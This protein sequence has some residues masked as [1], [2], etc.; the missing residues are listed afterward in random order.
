M[1]REWYRRVFVT[2]ALLAVAEL[3]MWIPLPG[4][5]GL[6]LAMLFPNVD[7][8]QAAV[9]R[10]RM[11]PGALGI[12]PYVAASVLVVLVLRPRKSRPE[13]PED[14]ELPTRIAAMAIAFLQG[15]AIAIRWGSMAAASLDGG[16][17]LPMSPLSYL[18]IATSVA[19]GTALLIVLAHA[20][21]RYGIGNGVCLI[22]LAQ[23]LRQSALGFNLARPHGVASQEA[24]LPTMVATGVTLALFVRFLRERVD[25]PFVPSLGAE[26]DRS[27]TVV[28]LRSSGI[29]V[30]GVQLAIG[31]LAV[32]L[33]LPEEW[34]GLGAFDLLRSH[35]VAWATS[36]VTLSVPLTL[37]FTSWA[38]DPE[39]LG[40][41]ASRWG[42][43]LVQPGLDRRL[44]RGMLPGMLLL[45]VAMVAWMLFAARSDW[46]LPDFVT[47]LIVA[48]ISTSVYERGLL[49]SRLAR[50][51]EQV[52]ASF[53]CPYCRAAGAAEAP[54]CGRCGAGFGEDLVCHVH[55]DR[56]S[57][58][59]C[60]ACHAALCAECDFPLAG[61]HR[62]Q[63]H[64]ELDMTEGWAV[65]ARPDSE[66]EA[67]IIRH[68][69][70]GRGLKCEVMTTTIAPLLGT[71]GIYEIS[72]TVLLFPFANCGGGGHSVLVPAIDAD[73]AMSLVGPAAA[74]T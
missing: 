5:I 29:G 16:G 53:E 46:G 55:D 45:S 44:E 3:L 66:C 38:Y 34:P 51:F 12:A 48:A 10:E 59:R 43:M 28:G 62:C 74:Q 30:R 18:A 4:A 13:A 6:D 63:A 11:S 67:G 47:L 64:R 19:A 31:S 68:H 20:I 22:A 2:L 58:A 54:F 65:V 26:T 9:L 21:T 17:S 25:L 15:L 36:V 37:I 52:G 24:V 50:E 33:A 49:H 71:L 70:A 61:H 72:P 23:L 42:L 1:S 73:R 8:A 60:A 7:P 40:A 41:I 56:A 57:V 69:L 14:P 39:R 35:G 27:A 32:L